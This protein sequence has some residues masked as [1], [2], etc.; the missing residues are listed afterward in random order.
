MGRRLEILFSNKTPPVSSSCKTPQRLYACALCLKCLAQT[1]FRTAENVASSVPMWG[2]MPRSATGTNT[3]RPA[4]RRGGWPYRL[5]NS[6]GQP[7]K[8]LRAENSP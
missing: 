4:P 3:A 1:P 6:L 2:G 8:L 5:G 7:H